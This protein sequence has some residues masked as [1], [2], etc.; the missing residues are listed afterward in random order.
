MIFN[1]EFHWRWGRRSHTVDL[2]SGP[3]RRANQKHRW[4]MPFLKRE[5]R[6]PEDWIICLNTEAQ[7]ALWHIMNAVIPGGVVTV[8]RYEGFRVLVDHSQEE[9]VRWIR[10]TEFEWRDVD[11]APVIFLDIDG[12][13]VPGDWIRQ[14]DVERVNELYVGVDEWK[15]DRKNS[16][17]PY[18]RFSPNCV[19][20][21]NRVTEATGADLVISSVWRGRG[22][23]TMRAICREQGVEATVVGRTGSESNGMTGYLRSK[24][25]RGTEIAHWLDQHP[26]VER[27]VILDDDHDMGYLYDH[28]V[29]CDP[30]HGLT[31]FEAN[32][33]I[34]FLTTNNE[35]E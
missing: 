21:L 25:G 27:F 28:L 5:G 30:Q 10:K 4:V 35:E 23:D 14:F 18:P 7:N 34:D 11:C 6:D 16:R 9:P 13:M 32:L 19:A 3:F 31:D 15:R 17:L 33:V 12:V 22:L 8:G 29:H 20:E 2:G 24:A 1:L 26:E